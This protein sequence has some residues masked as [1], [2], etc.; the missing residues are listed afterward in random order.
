MLIFQK[1]T[2]P[3]GNL[4]ISVFSCRSITGSYRWSQMLANPLQRQPLP[5]NSL[6]LSMPW[7]YQALSMAES[8]EAKASNVSQGQSRK[9]FPSLVNSPGDSFPR[10]AS[11]I[12]LS[13]S[14]IFS[15]LLCTQ[16][17]ENSLAIDLTRLHF[18]KD[19]LS[20]C[21]TNHLKEATS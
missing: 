8:S 10:G 20:E 19:S 17:R 4:I 12:C 3:R 21:K 13:E 16:A 15:L 5:S 14:V 11:H 18:L 7:K 6:H 9:T 2:I 1:G